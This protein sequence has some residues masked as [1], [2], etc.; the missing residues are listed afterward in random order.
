M[1]LNTYNEFD[2]NNFD[3]NIDHYG[4]ESCPPN[5]AFGPSVRNN[6]VLHYIIEGSG[7]FTIYN[8]VTSLGT[9]DIF[10]LPKDAVTYYQADG[11]QPWSLTYGL[12]F[13]D[14][15]RKAFYCNLVLWQNVLPQVKRIQKF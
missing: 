4:F 1:T 2:N 7:Q 15:E 12:V 14:R 3:L 5:Y 8:K 13:P 11:D 6:F 10:I 9:G